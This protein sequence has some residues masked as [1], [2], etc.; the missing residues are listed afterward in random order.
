M[1]MLSALGNPS[2]YSAMGSPSRFHSLP[3]SPSRTLSPAEAARPG[4]SQPGDSRRGRRV[5]GQGDFDTYECQTCKNR[6]YQD[7]SNDPCVSFKTPTRVKP[8]NAAY[9]IRSHEAEHVAHAWAEAAQEDEEIV[10][11]S[12]TYHTDICP[13]C[14]RTYMSGGTTRTVFRSAPE[15]YEQEPVKKGAYLDL[16]A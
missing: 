11:Q 8:E 13:E 2:F 3:M 9:A 4:V 6:K 10:S 1:T 16:T 14:G 5:S 7:G 12:V 15:T